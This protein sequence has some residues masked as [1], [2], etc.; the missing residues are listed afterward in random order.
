MIL[1]RSVAQYTLDPVAKK[2]SML[3]SCTA[4]TVRRLL[5]PK[6][7]KCYHSKLKTYLDTLHQKN[8]VSL[9]GMIKATLINIL[10]CEIKAENSFWPISIMCYH[11]NNSNTSVN[12]F[13]PHP[14]KKVC[15][16][17]QRILDFPSLQRNLVPELGV[18]DIGLNLQWSI[19]KGN[20]IW[21]DLSRSFRIFCLC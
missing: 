1:S 16:W 11:L 6:I 21:F 2:S 8:P 9:K 20:K 14:N 12:I 4:D 10:Q 17:A 18:G 7:H 3:I 15:S 5:L 13:P 19:S